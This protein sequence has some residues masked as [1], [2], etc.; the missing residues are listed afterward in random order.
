MEYLAVVG[1]VAMMGF[2]VMLIARWLN[3][4]EP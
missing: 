2:Y 1:A 4:S 3:R